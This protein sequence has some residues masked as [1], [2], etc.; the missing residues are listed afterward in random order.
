MTGKGET[1]VMLFRKISHLSIYLFI[2]YSLSSDFFRIPMAALVLVL[3]GYLIKKHRPVAI[4]LARWNIIATVLSICI[5]FVT[6]AIK[7]QRT[8]LYANYKNR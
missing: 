8:H 5:I 4:K 1:F 7:C 6:V 2:L 3:A